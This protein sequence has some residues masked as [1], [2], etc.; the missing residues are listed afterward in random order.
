MVAVTGVLVAAAYYIQNMRVNEKI[1]RRDI[2]FQR[3]NVN[4]LQHYKIFYD[5]VRMVDWETLEEFRR[6]YS[7]WTNPEAIAEIMYIMNHYNSIG[8]M[9]KDGIVEADEVYKLYAPSSM[10]A[11]YE[12]FLPFL[13]TFESE[14]VSGFKYLYEYTRKRYPA[15]EWGLSR[16]LEEELERDRRRVS[17]VA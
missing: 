4:V 9:L 16:S 8:I 11:I 17:S 6:K 5:V 13:N 2:V 1:R 14:Y 7:R 15:S 12:K 3:L 10:I